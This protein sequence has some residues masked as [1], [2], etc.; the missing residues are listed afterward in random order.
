MGFSAGTGGPASVS[1]WFATFPSNQRLDRSAHFGLVAEFAGPANS[2]R[3]PSGL[4][5]ATAAEAAW[6]KRVDIALM[7]C[8]AM[9]AGQLQRS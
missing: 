6:N 5:P 3:F 7:I 2:S 8:R 9:D 4:R 1:I